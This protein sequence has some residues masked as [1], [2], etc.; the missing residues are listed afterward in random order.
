MGD[1]VL[2]QTRGRKNA[3]IAFVFAG[4]M[5]SKAIPEKSR[6]DTNLDLFRA[7]SYSLVDRP[8]GFSLPGGCCL[9]SV[10]AFLVLDQPESAWRG[11]CPGSGPSSISLLALRLRW[12][13]KRTV[14]CLFQLWSRI[15]YRQLGEPGCFVRAKSGEREHS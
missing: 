2:N 5:K 1:S 15:D 6:N 3:M 13:L 10:S 11:S 7:C 4:P 14:A 8:N 12:Y 9:I